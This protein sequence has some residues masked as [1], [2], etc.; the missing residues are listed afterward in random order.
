M[1]GKAQAGA[2][3]PTASTMAAKTTDFLLGFVRESEPVEAEETED[4]IEEFREF[5][6]HVHPEDFAT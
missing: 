6:D 5:L 1:N 3:R 4:E 2:V